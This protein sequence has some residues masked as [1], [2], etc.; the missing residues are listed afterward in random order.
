[1]HINQI[2]KS[3]KISKQSHLN[4]VILTKNKFKFALTYLANVYKRINL[5]IPKYA[6]NGK[7][8]PS[9]SK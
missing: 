9:I 7:I 6:S 1:M 3:P 8:K 5:N 2:D 4:K